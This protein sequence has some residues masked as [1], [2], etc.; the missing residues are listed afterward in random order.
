MS[1]TSGGQREFVGRGMSRIFGAP[2]SWIALFGA[3]TGALSLVPMLFYPGGGGFISVGLVIF[4]PL[5]GL[6]LGPGGGFLAGFIGGVI[7]MFISPAAY[8]LGFIDVFFMGAFAGLFYGLVHPRYRKF[9]IPF[10]IVNL[11]VMELVP[12]YI[13]GKAGGFD[14]MTNPLTYFFIY[15]WGPIGLLIYLFALKPIFK[16]M[17]H[18]NLF[19]RMVVYILYVYMGLSQVF[20]PEGWIYMLVLHYPLSLSMIS[21]TVTWVVLIP[22]AIAAGIVATFVIRAMEQT[23]LPH[24]IGSVLDREGY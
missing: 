17:G 11:I 6:I 2:I 19:I 23:G 21:M 24:V 20:M 12:Y 14:Q 7:G 13:P 15:I 18:P 16:A 22:F 5:A 3:L 4:L 9:A 1:D 8:P 10:F